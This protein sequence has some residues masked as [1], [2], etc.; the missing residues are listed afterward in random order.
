MKVGELDTLSEENYPQF[1]DE[2]T[3]AKSMSMLSGDNSTRIFT[4]KDT[5]E[6]MLVD[7]AAATTANYL[8]FMIKR[9]DNATSEVTCADFGANDEN[10]RAHLGGFNLGLIS[11]F[12][13]IDY[14]DMVP[15]E[16]PV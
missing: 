15:F 7:N 1:F 8:N 6:Y 9:C 5:E 14:K 11:A 13:F 3:Y 4:L 16:G 10:L 2:G 12:N